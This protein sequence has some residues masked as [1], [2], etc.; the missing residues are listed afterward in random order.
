MTITI[1]AGSY[2]L[3]ATKQAAPKVWLVKE[4]SNVG[5]ESEG[6]LNTYGTDTRGLLTTV[7]ELVK[8]QSR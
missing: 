4:Y 8:K 2:K 7:K 3:R 6:C 1:E 5:L